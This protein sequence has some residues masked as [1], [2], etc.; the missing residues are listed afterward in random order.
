M[1]ILNVVLLSIIL[2]ELMSILW[3]GVPGCSI[4]AHT[5]AFKGPN[6]PGK[7]LQALPVGV[8]RA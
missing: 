7:P 2:T 3:L 6:Q 4:E 8:A 1:S 5:R